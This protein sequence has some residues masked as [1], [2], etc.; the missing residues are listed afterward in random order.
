MTSAVLTPPHAF[1]WVARPRVLL[2]TF[3]LALAI[4]D[5]A[6]R[7]TQWLTAP[8]PVAQSETRA[9]GSPSLP[10]FLTVAAPFWLAPCEQ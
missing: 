5:Q 6:I 8:A 2:A 10:L 3:V 9:D 4:M 7:L 1:A